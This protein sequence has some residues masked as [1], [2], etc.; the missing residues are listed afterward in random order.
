MQPCAENA[1]GHGSCRAGKC[2]CDWGYLK[3]ACADP[4]YMNYTTLWDVFQILVASL[5]GIILVLALIGLVSR[6]KLKS[7]AVARPAATY[8]DPSRNL[9]PRDVAYGLNIAAIC[10]RLVW[11]VD[12]VSLRGACRGWVSTLLGEVQLTRGLLD[13]AGIYPIALS[14]CVLLRFSQVLWLVAF[15]QIGIVW[16]Y[17]GRSFDLSRELL[18]AHTSKLTLWSTVYVMLCD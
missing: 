6:Q 4:F 3:P 12:P 18:L 17:V 10:I 7:T 15:T 11:I 13:P 9:N 8:G 2:V 5:Q 1:C 14:N 16:S